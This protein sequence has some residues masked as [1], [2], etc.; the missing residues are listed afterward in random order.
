V[1][2]LKL[3]PPKRFCSDR[4]RKKLYQ[5]SKD[6]NYYYNKKYVPVENQH[7]ALFEAQQPFSDSY[8]K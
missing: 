6:I 2:A 4:Q 7:P 5:A 1:L 8:P 3:S